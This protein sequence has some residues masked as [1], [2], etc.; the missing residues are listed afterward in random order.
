MYCPVKEGDIKKYK[1][2][3][4]CPYIIYFNK[5]YNYYQNH[6]NMI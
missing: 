4:F 1:I 6:N 2:S 3:S 5:M